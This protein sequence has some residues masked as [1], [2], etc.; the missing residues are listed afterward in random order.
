MTASPRFLSRLL[1]LVLFCAGLACAGSPRA[2]VLRHVPDD[3]ALCVLLEGLR[4]RGN[5]LA[6]SP[7][8]A[9]F[10]QSA[11]G[12][13]AAERAEVKQLLAVEKQVAAFTGL[14]AQ[15]LRDEVLGDLVVLA[16][17]PG[18]PGKPE[19]EQGLVLV[20]ARDPK[21]LA[22]LIRHVNDLEKKSGKLAGLEERT[23]RGVTYTC[24][25]EKDAPTYYAVRG[26]LLLF[27]GQ[28]AM[29]RRAIEADADL[30][31]DAV[32][33][34]EQ[35]LQRLGVAGSLVTLWINPRAYDAELALKLSKTTFEAYWKAL[36][37]L[38]V[39]LQLDS[40]VTL[41]LAVTGRPE[42]VSPA[43]RAMLKSLAEPNKLWRALPEE[44]LFA[45]AG[46][47]DFAALLDL[48]G[49]F[50]PKEGQQG[51]VGEL[52]KLGAPLGKNFVREVLPA[53]GPDLGLIVLPPTQ[54]Q[55]GFIPRLLLSLRVK[56][57]E[58][59]VDRALLRGLDTL[60]TLVLLGHNGKN[61]DKLLSLK[62]ESLGKIDLSYL[63]GEGVFPVGVR[64]AFG[65]VRGHLTL[66]SSP[67]VLRALAALLSED[68]SLDATAPGAVPVVRVS[69]AAWRAYLTQWKGEIVKALVAEG[70]Q[71]N[72]AEKLVVA[73]G[74][75]LEYLDR[76]EVRHQPGAGRILLQVSLKPRWALK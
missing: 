71:P 44:P 72:E 31:A 28:E 60:A 48:V 17:R 58:E 34:L 4:D 37:G 55:K 5:A 47:I 74:M 62:Q 1:P 10:A 20:H 12:K 73:W 63:T 16:Y 13:S 66:A 27:S 70:S 2:E 18:P 41:S 15:R 45:V 8:V 54:E 21:A 76:L 61:S 35:A 36:E 26:S 46:R 57:T 51:L 25:K 9:N 64:P 59:A 3:T 39:A 19:D 65:F 33:P 49:E 30:K 6:G 56:P 52:Q 11:L 38:A 32:A 53:L 29:L 42:K 22:A 69:F 40:D 43:A 50:L 23:H 7:F 68:A 67:E 24:R 14:T 75:G